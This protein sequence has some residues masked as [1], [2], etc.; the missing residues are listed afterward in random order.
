MTNPVILSAA[1]LMG[2]PIIDQLNKD[3]L[4]VIKIGDWV[5]VDGEKGVIEVTKKE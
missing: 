5:V 3:P 2:M 4:E 1:R